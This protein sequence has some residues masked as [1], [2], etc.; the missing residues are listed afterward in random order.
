MSF[1]CL[2][3]VCVRVFVCAVLC[4]AACMGQCYKGDAFRC[5]SCPFL[6]K[7]A[8]KPGTTPSTVMLDTSDDI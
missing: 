4:R 7:P 6:G 3:R 8:F 1:I 5:A 2:T